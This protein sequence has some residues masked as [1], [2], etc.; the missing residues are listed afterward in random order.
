[1]TSD[2]ADKARRIIEAQLEA[3]GFDLDENARATISSI[4][5][6]SE[7]IKRRE[8]LTRLLRLAGGQAATY[9]PERTA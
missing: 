2:P 4:E 8:Q 3:V 5:R 1:M 9:A 6:R 7:L